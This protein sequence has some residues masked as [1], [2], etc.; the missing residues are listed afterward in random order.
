MRSTRSSASRWSS[1]PHRFN[2]QSRRAIER[3]GAQLDGMLRSHQVSP[4]GT[5]RD[6]AVYSITAGRVARRCKRAPQLAAR[7]AALTVPL[8]RPGEAVAMARRTIDVDDLVAVRTPGA[9]VAVARRRA[10]R[11]LRSRSY[12]MDD[13]KGHAST[14]AAVDA[15]RR[16]AR[17]HAVRRQGRPAGWSARAATGSPSS[18]SA[19]SRATRTKS[20]SS[21]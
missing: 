15:R 4:D 9:A 1:A 19:N 11:L 3:L 16:A 7:Q 17:A 21:T 8:C 5:L 13:N 18:P 12:S 14:L 2:T 6:T 10:G 20:R